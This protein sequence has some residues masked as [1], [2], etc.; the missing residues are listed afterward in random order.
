MS[1][2][3]GIWSNFSNRASSLSVKGS[4]VKTAILSPSLPS[5]GPATLRAKT[6]KMQYK[7]P[8]ALDKIYPLAYEVLEKESES[9]YDRISKERD[10]LSNEDIEQLKIQAELNNPEVVFNSL[11][12]TN[13]L[14]RSQPV[15]RH[16]LKK[17]WESRDKMVTMQRLE[18][19]HVI[20]DTLSTL[21]PQVDV[22]LR[23]SHNNVSTWIE[24]GS[25]ISSNVSSRPPEL[26]IVEFK[27][28]LND[29]YTILI[30][31]P[32]TPDV[33]NDSYSTTLQWGLKNVK[34]TNNDSILD[35]KKLDSNPGFEF[36]PY[37]PSVPEKNTGNQRYAVWVFR[38][39]G[40]LKTTPTSRDQFN[41]RSFVEEN[42]LEAIGAHVWRSVWDMNTENVR[43]MYGLPRGMIF[44]RERV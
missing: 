39:N 41:I 32:D 2:S 16:Y 11:F 22:K 34:L 3:R 36:M 9:I 29:L 21:D 17:K 14:D 28:S 38:Q 30:V 8:V 4:A 5:N 26:E 31:N 27:E 23:F 7:S 42:S 20:P 24:P 33:E 1:V 13:S 37:L 40:E 10:S 18:S 25:I 44:S 6:N 43:K 15:Y 35:A 12:A 19:L